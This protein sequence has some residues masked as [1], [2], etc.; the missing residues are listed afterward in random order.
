MTGVYIVPG[1]SASGLFGYNSGTI[2]FLGVAYTSRFGGVAG[3]NNGT[4]TGCYTEFTPKTISAGNRYTTVAQL[5]ETITNTGTVLVDFSSVAG[6]TIAVNKRVTVRN[7]VG[8]IVFRGTSSSLFTG[9][10]IVIE[11]STNVVFDDFRYQGNANSSALRFSGTGTNGN[12]SV[13]SIGSGANGNSVS[14]LG[15]F[16][17]LE[18]STNLYICGYANLSVNSQNRTGTSNPTTNP[19]RQTVYVGAGTAGRVPITITAPSHSGVWIQ[20]YNSSSGSDPYL[21]NASGGGLNDDGG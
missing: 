8:T 13:I 17:T 4:I 20:S 5:P 7:S 19:I 11:G 1:N 12:P 14:G 15:N 18:G 2:K 3:V 10:N 6:T 21:Y 16:R 9:L